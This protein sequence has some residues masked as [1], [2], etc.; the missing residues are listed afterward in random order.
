MRR[1]KC[2]S[3]RKS[4]CLIAVLINENG[5][6]H[7]EYKSNRKRQPSKRNEDLKGILLK[8]IFKQLII[9]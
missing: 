9:T 6:Q 5:T 7:S 3:D 4:I 1:L 2:K 8:R